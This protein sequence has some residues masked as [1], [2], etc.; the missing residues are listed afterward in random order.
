MTDDIF[1]YID[2]ERTIA[3][4]GYDPRELKPN[5]GK[6]VFCYCK[7][8]NAIRQ[9]RFARAKDN[10]ICRDCFVFNEKR[11]I[12]NL[13]NVEKTLEMFGYD[14]TFLKKYSEKVVLVKCPNCL[15]ERE[16]PFCSANK[17]K[18]CSHCS[19]S[20]ENPSNIF[21]EKHIFTCENC[22]AQRPAYF[23]QVKGRKICKSC[24]IEKQKKNIDIYTEEELLHINV[25]KT[26]E[27][28]GYDISEIKKKSKN[29]VYCICSE[30][31]EECIKLISDALRTKR[32]MACA[33][34]ENIKKA[35]KKNIGT[36]RSKETRKKISQR[37]GLPTGIVTGLWYIKEDGSKIW[38]RSS[39]ESKF[40]DWLT[41]RGV[42]WKY[43]SKIFPVTFF[44]NKYKEFREGTYRPDFF[45]ENEGWYEVKGWWRDDAKPKFEAFKAQYP[46]EKITLLMKPELLALGID[47]K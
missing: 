36:P 47:V 6:L 5:S 2:V 22:K 14:P 30:C 28:F 3:E 18:F 20:K 21:P 19:K 23:S 38:M 44:S 11:E 17:S 8:C 24:R 45:V 33:C 37:L 13:I 26:K 29:R 27:V 41:S 10:T 40:A 31:K 9:L 15:E 43:E 4:F 7:Q 34:R 16:A 35:I 46:D 32:C 39:W 25:K 1:K 42:S 12:S